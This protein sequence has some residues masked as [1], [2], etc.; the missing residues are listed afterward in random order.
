MCW[1]QW[2]FESMLERMVDQKR[3]VSSLWM[4]HYRL[5]VCVM[6][7]TAAVLAMSYCCL[8][9]GQY[10][11][12]SIPYFYCFTSPLLFESADEGINMKPAIKICSCRGEACQRHVWRK[13]QSTRSSEKQKLDLKKKTR[14]KA[15]C[16]SRQDVIL[17]I[18][19]IAQWILRLFNLLQLPRVFCEFHNHSFTDVLH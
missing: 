7:L 8:R 12:L 17:T 19:A 6:L 4:P 15:V 10:S 2:N 13:D 14:W 16:S 9:V 18:N 3:A 1:L 11:L 5:C